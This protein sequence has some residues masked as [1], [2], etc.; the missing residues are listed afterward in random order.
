MSKKVISLGVVFFLLLNLSVFG[1]TAEAEPYT[2]DEFPS[3]LLDLRRF[4]VLAVG[5]VPIT[6]I[7]SSFGYGVYKSFFN[8]EGVTGGFS[9]TPQFDQ[10]E[11]KRILLSGTI[12]S[13]T[14]AL[15]DLIIG[16]LDQPA[17]TQ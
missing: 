5:T 17:K 11:R 6:L 13:I 10:T 7:V 16:K 8:Q 12:L 4:E 14:I 2:E 15:V 9:L 3:W 1:Q